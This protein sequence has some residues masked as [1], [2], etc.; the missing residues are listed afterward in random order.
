MRQ[1][2]AEKVREFDQQ[3]N[4]QRAMLGERGIK[5]DPIQS[6][7]AESTVTQIRGSSLLMGIYA[8]PN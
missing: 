7:K 1:G 3:V 5:L 6:A 8:V 2:I 4:A